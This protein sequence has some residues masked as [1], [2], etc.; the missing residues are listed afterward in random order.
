VRG[1]PPTG[2]HRLPLSRLTKSPEGV[3]AYTIEGIAGSTAM[4]NTEKSVNPDENVAHV[5]APS[6]DL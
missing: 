6:I 5:A 2:A 3:P 1:N 4:A